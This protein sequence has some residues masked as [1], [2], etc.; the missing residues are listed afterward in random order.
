M[1]RHSFIKFNLMSNELEMLNFFYSFYLPSVNTLSP[2]IPSVP[3]SRKFP[4]LSIFAIC[5]TMFCVVFGCDC[6]F[7]VS[8]GNTLQTTAG[9]E[10]RNDHCFVFT[11][12]AQEMHSTSQYSSHIV[13]VEKLLKC[14]LLL[15]TIYSLIEDTGT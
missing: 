5:N 15:F 8:V 6:F 10:R 11:L 7:A 4:Q 12:S 9:G 3:S 2:P 13:Y 1:Y 14:F